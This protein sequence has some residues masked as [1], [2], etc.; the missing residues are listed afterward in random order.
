MAL[1]FSQQ[2]PRAVQKFKRHSVQKLET[3]DPSSEKKN[4]KNK[5]Q[6]VYDD[7]IIFKTDNIH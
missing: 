2:L 5:Q 4:P 1:Y 6:M 3:F 7:L